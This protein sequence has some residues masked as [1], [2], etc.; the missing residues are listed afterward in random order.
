MRSPVSVSQFGTA[1]IVFVPQT[2]GQLCPESAFRSLTGTRL[3]I[4]YRGVCPCESEI[5]PVTGSNS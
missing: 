3:F 5:D 4:A 1:A 2:C